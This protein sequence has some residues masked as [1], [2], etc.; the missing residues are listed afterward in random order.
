MSVRGERLL[1]MT[2]VGVVWPW[3]GPQVD[4]GR[5]SL[6]RQPFNMR[7]TLHITIVSLSMFI[8]VLY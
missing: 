8:N 4:R 6:D 2:A 3:P 5:L 1:Q 7:S